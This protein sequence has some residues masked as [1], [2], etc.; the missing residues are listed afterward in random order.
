MTVTEE[1]MLHVASPPLS[2]PDVRHVQKKLKQLGYSP[3]P[4]DG[5]YGVATA[6]AVRA[7]QAE[8]DLEVDGVVG[9]QTL[10]ALEHAEPHD[11]H[12]NGH[13]SSVGMGALHEA[14]KHLGVKEHPAGTNHTPFGEWFGVDGVPWCNI[15]V[16]YCF[17]IGAHHTLCKGFNGAGVYAKGCTYVPTTEAWLR[18]TGQWLGRTN[19]QPG[20]IAIYDFDGGEADHIGIVERYLG[21][22][23]FLAIEGNTGSGSDADGGEVE[24]RT[25][26]LSQV[27][28]FGRVR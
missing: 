18:A 1:R 16:S 11:E 15:F 13:A 24:R 3:G 19:P 25:R 8:E 23:Q 6:A 5:V 28:G 26:T 4:V 9:P 20:D 21:N 22:G 10:A 12:D 27:H 2:G 14:R 7:F 17:R